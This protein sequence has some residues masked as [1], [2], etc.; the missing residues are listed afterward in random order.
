MTG[1]QQAWLLARFAVAKK[2]CPKWWRIALAVAAHETGFGMSDLAR[3]H[4]N[5]HGHKYCPG[6]RG[7]KPAD[8]GQHRHFVRPEQTWKSFNYLLMKSKFYAYVRHCV[9]EL[10]NSD[11]P[12]RN[13]EEIVV[14]AMASTYCPDDSYQWQDYVLEVHDEICRLDGSLPA[15]AEDDAYESLP[16]ANRDVAHDIGLD[17]F[18]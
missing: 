6:R 14:R 8:D 5:L 17:G 16:Y 7:Q 11:M 4:L 2:Y 13:I 15:R 18:L 12:H 9:K 1:H 10:E 3:N